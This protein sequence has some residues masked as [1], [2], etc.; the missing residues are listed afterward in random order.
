MRWLGTTGG[1]AGME[2]CGGTT[3]PFSD[4]PIHAPAKPCRISP[5]LTFNALLAMHF[6]MRKREKSSATTN[7]SPGAVQPNGAA[8]TSPAAKP[9]LWADSSSALCKK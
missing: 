9:K 4:L 5:R 6:A 8:A 2:R 3:A 1:H 7:A